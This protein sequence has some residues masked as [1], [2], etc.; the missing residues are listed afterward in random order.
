MTPRLAKLFEFLE[1]TPNDAFLLFAI[2]KEYENI[3]DNENTKQYYERL[4]AEQEQYV[5][6]YYHL[7]KFYERQ[8]DVVKAIATYKKGMEIAKS[9]RDNHAFGELNTALM[10]ID[11]DDDFL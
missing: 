4:V 3:N 1:N 11:D 9:Q 10:L 2:A 7:G 6:T 5:G 8:A